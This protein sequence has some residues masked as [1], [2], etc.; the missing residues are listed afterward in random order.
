MDVV[1]VF[2]TF[3]GILVW[4]ELTF[5]IILW[6]LGHPVLGVIA[7]LTTFGSATTI[8]KEKYIDNN[9]NVVKVK[10]YEE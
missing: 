8:I 7:F 10:E 5:G 9:G 6:L 3:I 1:D 2:W 4:P